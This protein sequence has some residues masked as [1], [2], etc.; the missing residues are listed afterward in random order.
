[1]QRRS[2][3]GK[4]REESQPGFARL[5]PQPTG[6]PINIGPSQR[7]HFRRAPQPAKSGKRK[8]QPPIIIGARRQHLDS[9]V[10]AYKSMTLGIAFVTALQVGK[11]AFGEQPIFHR[12][13]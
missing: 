13:R 12:I 8:D 11:R 7:Q 6:R 1:M 2:N 3:L 5:D 9:N 10:G 4:H